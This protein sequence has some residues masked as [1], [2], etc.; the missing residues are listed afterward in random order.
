MAKQREYRARRRA[1]SVAK[2]QP[3]EAELTSVQAAEV[4]G[5]SR[6]RV[7]ALAR[8][9][10]LPYRVDGRSWMYPEAAVRQ[11]AA[12]RSVRRPGDR[13]A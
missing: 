10:V 8:D 2:T 7:N 12:E 5:V 3:A 13:S 9:G 11:Y 4:L 6:G 1:G